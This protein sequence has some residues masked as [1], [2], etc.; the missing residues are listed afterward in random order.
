MPQKETERFTSLAGVFDAGRPGYPPELSDLLF[1]G[2][3]DPAKVVVAD[4]GAGTGTSSRILAERGASVFAVEPNA[5]MRAKAEQLPRITWIDGTAERTSL[6]DRSVDL[7]GAFQAFHWFD[8][9]AT[10]KEMTRILRTGGR[11]V[12]VFY[13]RDESDPFTR[14]YG[15]IVRKY[16]TDDTERRRAQALE[17]FATWPGWHSARR[18][19]LAHEHILDP[20]GM[21]QRVKS[22]SYLPQEGPESEPVM[23]EARALFERYAE[24]GRVRMCLETLGVI[25][26]AR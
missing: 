16:A 17:A 21:T 3:G 20:G 6:P 14:A 10:F 7:V 15:D 22:T 19:R 8:R 18:F 24:T 5:A 4:L 23:R 25:A 13:E 12:V 11:A 1:E 9:A 26:Q 2:L